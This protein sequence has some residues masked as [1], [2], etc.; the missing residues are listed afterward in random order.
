MLEGRSMMVLKYL[1]SYGHELER[2]RV[3][4]LVD[5]KDTNKIRGP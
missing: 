1:N 5:V 2:V 3:A 4:W